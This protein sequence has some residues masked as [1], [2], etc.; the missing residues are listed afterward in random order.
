M[1][2]ILN[3]CMKY[4][5]ATHLHSYSCVCVCMHVCTCTCIYVCPRACVH[6]TVSMYVCVAMDSSEATW[7][8]AGFSESHYG[9]E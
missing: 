1:A 8:A 5:T 3:N 6:A 9:I 7:H 4:E 2:Y